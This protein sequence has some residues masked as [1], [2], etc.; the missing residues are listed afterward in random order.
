MKGGMALFLGAVVMS[1]ASALDM[2]ASPPNEGPV[3]DLGYAKYQGYYN[4]TYD[5]NV[6]K[7]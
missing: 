2:R 7:G 6:W 5:L 1:W 3:V 4:A